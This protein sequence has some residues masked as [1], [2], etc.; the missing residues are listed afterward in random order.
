M[1][2]AVSV[3]ILKRITASFL[4]GVLYTACPQ[5]PRYLTFAAMQEHALTKQADI[6]GGH[7]L[8]LLNQVSTTAANHAPAWEA[9]EGINRFA[10]QVGLG[11][12]EVSFQ[13][14]SWRPE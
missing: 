11:C 14:G 7:A 3:F 13:G 1:L 4:P 9:A 5:Y 6:A 12:K 10:W 8:S 2:W